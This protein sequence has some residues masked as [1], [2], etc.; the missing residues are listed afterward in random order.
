MT[1][2]TIPDEATFVVFQ[3]GGGGQTS[4][5]ISFSLFDKAD[6]HASVAGVEVGQAG[7]TFAGN[8]VDGGYAGGIVTLSVEAFNAQVVIWREVE[9]GRTTNFFPAQFTSAKDVDSAFNRIEAKVQENRRDIDRAFLSPLGD[10]PAEFA[11]A[12]DRANKQVFTDADGNFVFLTGA[13]LVGSG[14]NAFVDISAAAA[15]H[16]G[17]RYWFVTAGGAVTATVDALSGAASGQALEFFTGDDAAAN[18]VTIQMSGADQLTVD[19]QTGGSAQF[20]I[21]NA[22]YVLRKLGAVARIQRIA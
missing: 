13:P 19:G 15:L 12:S 6:L 22:T 1:A 21:P 9:I 7:F 5:P 2:L 14:V 10:S 3:V 8:P 17:A 20:A 18:P 4:F 16:F 11:S